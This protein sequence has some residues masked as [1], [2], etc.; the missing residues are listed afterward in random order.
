MIM[1]LVPLSIV[2]E[3]AHTFRRFSVDEFLSSIQICFNIL[4][5]C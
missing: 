3:Y 5:G 2:T 4:K 1:V